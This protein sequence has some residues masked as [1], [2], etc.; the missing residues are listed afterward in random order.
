MSLYDT[1]PWILSVIPPKCRQVGQ[2]HAALT[3][4]RFPGEEVGTLELVHRPAEDA[5]EIGHRV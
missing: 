3:M 4:L 1:E 2:V 5:V